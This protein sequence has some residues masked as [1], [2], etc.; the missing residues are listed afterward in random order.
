MKWLFDLESNGLLNDATKLHCAVAKNL[1]SGDVI[2]FT[3]HTGFDALLTLLEEAILL[4]GHNVIGFDLPLLKKFYPRF[5]TSAEIR[6][7]LIMA[8][9]MMPDTLEHDIRQK[10]PPKLRAKHSLEAWGQRLRCPKGSH[11]NF[12]TYSEEMLTYCIQDVEVTHRLWQYLN[13]HPLTQDSIALEHDVA[14]IICAQE[15]YGFFLN[16]LGSSD[17]NREVP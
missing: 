1:E 17:A 9:L 3:P 12:S 5:Q 13:A 11:Q 8:R 10:L 2:T 7:T 14:K 16:L 15:R 4:V 6:D